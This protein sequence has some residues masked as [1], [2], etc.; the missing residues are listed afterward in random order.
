MALL[1]VF[2]IYL[3]RLTEQNQF[4]IGWGISEDEDALQ[5]LACLAPV[6]PMDITVDLEQPFA[7]ILA[8]VET[9]Y[10]RLKQHHTFVRDL[11]ARYPALRSVP[12]LRTTHPWQVAVSVL[13]DKTHADGFSCTEAVGSLLTLQTDTHGAFRWLYDATRLDADQVQRMSE[14]LRELSLA[15]FSLDGAEMPSKRLNLLPAIERT[16]LLQTWN[17]TEQVYPSHLCIHQLFEAQVERTPDATALVYEGQ[18]LSYAELNARANRL[19]HQLIEL[20]VKPDT[21]VALYARRDPQ[22]LVG[23]LATL[24]AGG[25]YVPLDPT[26]PPERLAYMVTDS[27][28]TVL[29]SIGTPHAA[30]MQSLK[31]G[32]PVLD[33]QADV[34]QWAHQSADNPNADELSLDAQNLAY[35]IYTSGSTGR[36]KG[37]MVQ[38]QAVVNLVTAIA[39]ELGMTAQDRML[40]F[41]PLSFDTSVEEI[42]TPLTRGA[43]VVLRTDAWLAGAEQFWSLCDAHHVSVVDLPVQFWTQLAQEAAPV[44]NSVRAILIGG[45]ALSATARDAWFARDGHRPRLLNVYGPTETTVTATVHEVTDHESSWRTIGRPIDNTRLYILD[46]HSQPV[47]LGAVGELYIGG[48]GVARGYLNRPELTAERFVRDPFA[49][50]PNARM[51]KTGDLVRYLPDGKLEFLGRNDHQVK[52]RGFRIELGEI[53]AYLAQH[54][55]VHEA[56]VLATGEGQNKRLVAYVV[57]QADD[58]LANTLRMHMAAGLPEYMV[59]SAFVRLDAFPLTPNGKLDRRALPAPSAEAFAHQAYEAPQGELE[60]TLAAIWSELL[61]VE[62]ISRHDSFFALGGHSLLAVQLIER[63]RRRGLGISV[64]SLFDMPVLSTLAQSLGQHQEVVVPANRITLETSQL[65]PDLLPLIELTQAEIDRIVEQVPG[66]VANIQDIY[67]LSPLQDGILFHHLL[68]SEGDPYLLNMQLAFDTRERLDQYLDAVQQVVN[69]HDILR[70]AFVWEGLSKPAQVVWRHARLPVTELTFDPA[71]GPIAEQ[72]AQRFDSCHYRLDL[73]QAPLLH[74]AIA[75]DTDGRWLLVQLLHHLI[76]DHSALE[77]MHTE[78]RAFIEGRGD[79][80][81]AAQ[82]FR[83]LVAQA[84]LGVSQALHERFFTDMLAEVDEPTL[85]FALTEVHRDG[86]QA[87]E[88]HRMLPQALNDRL[89]DQAKRL[90][91]SLAS[92]CHLA[93]AQVLAR[94]SGQPRVVFGTVLFGRMQAGEGADSAMGLFINTLPLRVDLNGS[95]QACVRDTH[96]RLA[97]LLEHEHASLALA[98]RCSGVPA[99]T[100]LFSALLNYRHNA[101]DS[102]EHGILPGVKLLSVE[103]RDNYP[104]GLSIEDDG[105]A[106]GLTA[107]IVEP[108]N[109]DRVCGYMQQ[110]LHSLADALEERPDR[111]VQ[112][113]EVLPREEYELLLQTWNATEQVYPSHQ[114]IHQL[115]EAQVERTPDATALVYEGQTLS[116]AELNARANR[117]AHQL[118]EL[119][120]KPDTRVAL[121]AQRDPQMLVGIL[122][123]LKAGGAYV[124]LDPTYPPERLAY[125]VTDSMP[126]VLLSIGTPHAA[127]MQSLKAGV[128]VLDLQ[129][130]IAQWA[131]QSAGNPNADELSLDAQNLAY[132]IY[133]SGSTGRPKGVMVQHQAVVNLVTAIARELDMTAQDRMLQFASLSFDTSV[134]EILTPLTRGAAVV[135]RTDTWL[136]GAEQFWS[137]CDAHHVSVVDLP[138]QFWTQL[139]QEAAPVAN[140]VRAILI[141]G[142][143]LSATARDA[144]FARDGHRPRLLNVYGPTETTVTATVHEVTD[145]ERS[146]RTIGRPIDNTRLYILDT[147]SQ[148]VPLGAVGELY[149][150]GAGVARG[151]LNRP[152]L[153]AERFVRDP[154]SSE[155]DARMYRTGDLVRYLSDGKL[156]FLGRN[157]HQVKIRGFRI[158][159]GEIEACLAQHAQV[160]EAV[161]LATGEGQNKRLVAYVVAQADEQLVNTLR[162]H[163]ASALPEYMVPSAFV[164]LDAF[165]LTPNGKLDR[166]ALPAPSAEA[167][168]HQAYEAPQ[169]ELETTL[170][171]IWSE[172]LGVEKISRHDSFFALGGHS[173][174]AVQ[175][176]E[177]L[178]RRG[179]GISVRSLFDMPVLS[180]LA[181]SLGQHQEVV[182]PANRITLETSQLTPDLLPLIELTQAEIDRIVEQVPGG[183]A[184][185]QDIYALSPSQD[186]I[187]FHHLLVTDGDPYLLVAQWAFDTRERLDQYLDAVQ[188]VVNRHDIL[189]TAVV[190]EGLSTPAQVVWRHAP[191]S[192][193]EL[194]LDAADGPIAEQLAQRFDP[195]HYRLDLTQ[196]PLLHFAIAQDTDGRWLLVELLHHLIGDHS[197]DEMMHTEVQTFLMGQGKMLP[198]AQ[199]FRNFVAHV[200]LSANQASHE[201]FFT[202]MLADVSEP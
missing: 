23:I 74:F 134:E 144:W 49:N 137:L 122:A 160:H 181:Q 189:R 80:L 55:Q 26:Y 51:Y 81:P 87:S 196:A 162:T 202:D 102:D 85:P 136:A 129:T 71:D 195:R 37:V 126:T 12:A 76:G 173:L 119:G 43:A 132:V 10:E 191:L 91:V 174:L 84:R 92:L 178:R 41:A 22:M 67:A 62:K 148:P 167:F 184:N 39:R 73:T 180:T 61:G 109:S 111:P 158:E 34:A 146:W 165:P 11:I 38:H 32:V 154:F 36:P 6:V 186:G 190:W 153:T 19:A 201:R 93:W 106:L 83:Q 147:H 143:A 46:T 64:R 185:I 100:P 2:A 30:V 117:L 60:T 28:P 9:E 139:A 53:E 157:D 89:R 18:T 33:L 16:V 135:L 4:K 110:A 54:A 44:A 163:V 140:S 40:Q 69:R 48:A 107:K 97:A 63:L 59:P 5:T 145:H 108:L 20:G 75:Q 161:V 156:E 98:Q 50:E 176:I 101:M 7:K 77:V 112:Q 120:V 113:L 79:T 17:A 86:A 131:H 15:S 177:R 82:P 166:R 193:T 52:I 133:T 130:D 121:Y 127:V 171:A 164:R 142:D 103:E 124:P 21:R 65:T 169:G 66:G 95:V 175:L 194:M 138:V 58:Q 182:V 88:A 56:V 14:H 78:V 149:I 170:A 115:F 72:L 24:K 125:M 128:P 187:L 168:A 1:T 29:L 116:Y 35:V 118:I 198:A 94:A 183:V 192:V 114:C 199:P 200:R 31:A 96:A 104:I 57:A 70:T 68:A 99:G 188:Q 45:D 155:A 25:A 179:L 152:E 3:A 8:N 159:L 197:T 105:Q 42:L 47:P 27:M 13:S 172:L 151:Y 90:G 141:G 150:G 123:T